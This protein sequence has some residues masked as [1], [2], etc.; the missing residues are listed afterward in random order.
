MGTGFQFWKMKN[1][2]EVEGDDDCIAM[3]M[4]LI[5]LSRMFKMVNFMLCVFSHNL[6]LYLTCLRANLPVKG[7]KALFTLCS[8]VLMGD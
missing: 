4:C 3:G 2:L 7:K 8:W 1:G 5:A 6:R